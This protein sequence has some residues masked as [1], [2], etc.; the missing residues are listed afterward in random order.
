MVSDL[1]RIAVDA[2]GGDYAPHEIVKGALEAQRDIEVKVLLVGPQEVLEEQ[3][4]GYSRDSLEIVDASETIEMGEKAAQAVRTKEN[5]SLVIAARLCR[6][7]RADGFVSAGNTGA[8]M[9][10]AL[11]NWGRIRGI[12]RPAIAIVIPTPSGPVLLLDAGANAECRPDN[13]LQFAQM[14]SAYA[15]I[16]L[17]KQNPSLGLLNVGEEEGKGS[18]LYQEAHQLLK[19]ASLNF[20]GNIE[21]KDI[22]HAKADIV[23]CDG[24]TGNIVLK[25]LEGTI[26]VFF[27]E[28]KNRIRQSF[29][30]RTAGAILLPS[31]SELKKKLDYEEYG[32]APLLGVNGVCIISHG[33]SKAKAIRNAIR[34]ARQA[35]LSNLVGELGAGV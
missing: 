22:V 32:G 21:G 13:L 4:S 17:A 15:R 29:L 16:I 8:V 5:S 24:F 7:Q 14:G 26:E 34:V 23:V 27:S 31:L 11:L 19:A 1:V 33:K 3:L 28:I 25:L 20:L 6:E 30:N 12:N 18:E 35:V 10:A 2:M 9:A